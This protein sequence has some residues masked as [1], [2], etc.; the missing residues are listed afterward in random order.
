M[1]GVMDGFDLLG[2]VALL[3][4]RRSGVGGH[5]LAYQG[6]PRLCRRLF[7]CKNVDGRVSLGVMAHVGFNVS[8]ARRIASGRPGTVP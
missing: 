8:G 3:R 7:A 4:K 2:N 6:W 5:V 1:Y